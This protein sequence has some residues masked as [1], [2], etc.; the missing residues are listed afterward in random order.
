MLTVSLNKTFPSF[1]IYWSLI[2]LN[3]V[4]YYITVLMLYD[5]GQQV[6]DGSWG[7]W[8]K[9]TLGSCSVTCGQG[10]RTRTKTRLCNKPASSNGG[11]PCPGSDTSTTQ[12]SCKVNDCA[13]RYKAHTFN[14]SIINI[15][16]L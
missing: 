10:T 13:G 14:S 5:S 15:L 2:F 12:E 1:L 6:V 8:G 16:G 11:K 3:D 9:E 4:I 7:T